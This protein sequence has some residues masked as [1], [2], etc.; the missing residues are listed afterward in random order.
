[1]ARVGPVLPS[2]GGEANSRWLGE[3]RRGGSWRP[4]R[5]LDHTRRLVEART[6]REA[7]ANSTVPVDLA[8]DCRTDLRFHH[9]VNW[10]SVQFEGPAALDRRALDGRRD[11]A[12][13]RRCGRRGDGGFAGVGPADRCREWGDRLVGLRRAAEVRDGAG[14][15]RVPVLRGRRGVAPGRRGAQECLL[16][17]GA[18]GSSWCL[19]LVV[20]S[21]VVA[22]TAEGLSQAVDKDPSGSR[23]C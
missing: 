20:E 9:C 18:E 21:D 17:V 15:A 13:G 11:V 3:D 12:A 5:P 10:A 7:L 23:W 1:M 19:G 4:R 14:A 6:A 22:D 8:R 2:R 16:L